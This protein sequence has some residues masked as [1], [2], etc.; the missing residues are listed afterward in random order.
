M[1]LEITQECLQTQDFA[2]TTLCTKTQYSGT[3]DIGE[4]NIAIGISF[5]FVAMIFIIWFFKK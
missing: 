3:V 1:N 5:A 2:S 4:I